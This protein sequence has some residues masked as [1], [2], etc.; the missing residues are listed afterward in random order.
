M[1]EELQAL[2]KGGLVFYTKQCVPR[3]KRVDERRS[4]EKGIDLEIRA[5]L[6]KAETRK[7]KSGLQM[8]ACCDAY[9]NFPTPSHK[10]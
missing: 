6:G 1:V 3:G 4:I 5:V 10:C 9:S 7:D 8:H 2:P